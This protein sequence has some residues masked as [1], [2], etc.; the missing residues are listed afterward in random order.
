MTVRELIEALE[1]FPADL[2]VVTDSYEVE[3][4]VERDEIWYS[5]ET[6][7]QD[8]PIVKLIG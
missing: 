5:N 1:E 4:A 8:G 3:L 6:G 2:P 7:Y